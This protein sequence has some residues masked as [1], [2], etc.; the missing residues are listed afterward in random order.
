MED[1][2]R[3]IFQE[4]SAMGAKDLRLNSEGELDTRLKF[5]YRAYSK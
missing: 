2:I 1:A 4:L 3:S 5:Q